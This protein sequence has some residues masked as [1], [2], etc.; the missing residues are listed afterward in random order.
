M[1]MM[2]ALLALTMAGQP[3][4][5]RP[6]SDSTMRGPCI[7]PSQTGSFRV[8]A[9]RA[10]GKVGVTALV[11]LENVNGCLEASFITD[12]RGPAAI[13][14]LTL[15]DNVLKGRLKVTGEAADIVLRFDGTRVDGSI[16]ARKNEWR[17]EGSKTS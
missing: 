16:V 11:L 8:T 14:R 13:D 17:L 15:G 6:A 7:A 10:D 4:A 9:T 1:L 2:S 5:P 3:L 12:D